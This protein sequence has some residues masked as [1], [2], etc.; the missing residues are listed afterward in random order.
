MDVLQRF[1][2]FFLDLLLI[3]P[4]DHGLHRASDRR[5]DG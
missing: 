2:S 4:G 5:T 3:Q 1:Y